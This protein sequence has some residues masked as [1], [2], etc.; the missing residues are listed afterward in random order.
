[1]NST[2]KSKITELSSLPT[3]PVVI[4]KLIGILKNENASMGELVETIRHDQ[5]I[6]SRI[7]SIA[8]SPFFGY[9]G[10]I[11]SIE[12]AVLMLG[13]NLVRSISL[14]VSIF[15]MFPI[16][17]IT[18]KKMW[19]H[20]FKVASLSGL[21][22]SK[23]SINNSGVCFLAGLL[24]DIGRGIFLAINKSEHPLEGIETLPKLKAHELFE[25]EKLLFQCNHTDAA[26][27]FLEELFFPQEIILPVYYHHDLG[28]ASLSE[29]PHKDVI[30][31]IYL[32]EGLIQEIDPDD[33]ND[34][35]FS[36]VHSMLFKEAGFTTK[37]IEEIKKKFLL[38]VIS[39]NNFFE[40]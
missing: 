20:S 28:G 6:I 30:L 4:S 11:N 39:A 38:T 25:A 15:T 16:P 19:A 14:S 36:E 1:M 32:S 23:I 3:I 22:C 35:Q 9:P 13:F 24:H 17:Y 33:L 12:Q 8:N 2:T 5:S 18:L 10:R 27:W 37:D 31:T 29:L 26:R 34:G 40:L 7:V 21:L